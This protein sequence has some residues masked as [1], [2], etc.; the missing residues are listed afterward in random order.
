MNPF[1][2]GPFPLSRG[3]RLTAPPGQVMLL[4][5]RNGVVPL[6]P[7]Q[8]MTRGEIRFAK[9]S[10]WLVAT[11]APEQQLVLDAPTRRPRDEF[12]IQLRYMVTVT[13]AVR[14]YQDSSPN[15]D[16]LVEVGSMVRSQV[17]ALAGT[18]T[19][20]ACV[21]LRESI[22]RLAFEIPAS[23][24]VSCSDVHVELTERT[25]ARMDAEV[26]QEEELETM[27]RRARLE[28]ERA[29]LE[30]K[31]REQRETHRFE[32]IKSI[33]KNYDLE[34][35]PLMLRTLALQDNPSAAEMLDIR[36]R[37][38][39]ESF[40]HQ[41]ATLDFFTT[42]HEHQMLE[43]DVF[44]IL[45]EQAGDMVRRGQAERLRRPAVGP[46]SS[47]GQAAPREIGFK[48]DNAEVVRAA[49]VPQEPSGPS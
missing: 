21:D 4:E 25:R 37:L 48:G 14:F 31:Q 32:T 33:A 39:Q 30:H 2:S 27:R 10:Y 13:D 42:L 12:R 38:A 16:P 47:G 23:L 43:D 19:R 26:E 1:I 29:T 22:H 36:D 7:T 18:F 28:E 41:K 46:S 8:G 15:I 5:A 17:R 24:G 35:D 49:E 3:Q 11:H 40:D 9:S 45:M 34:L 20:D 6:H 44:K